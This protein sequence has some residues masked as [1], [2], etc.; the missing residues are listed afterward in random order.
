M[1]TG[2]MADKSNQEI[3][4]QLADLERREQEAA[5]LP[6]HIQ[7]IYSPEVLKKLFAHSLLIDMDDNNAK[8]DVI[9]ELVGDEDFMELGPGTN[10]VGLLGPDGCCHKIAMDRRGIVD[11]MTEFRRSP[12]LE[13][14]A[15]RAYETNGV[16]L[17]A[18]NVELMT[19][20]DY[21]NNRIHNLEICEALAQNYIFT[22]IGFA[23]K[24]FC[25][26]GIRQDGTLV[27]LDTGYL[28]PII[29]NEQALECP[30]CGRRLRYRPNY[31]GFTCGHCG[32]NFGFIDIY[33]RINTKV[34]DELY[35]GLTGFELP[36]F[37]QFNGTLYN[38]GLMKGGHI[39]SD[40]GTQV[41]PKFVPGTTMRFEDLQ[42]ILQRGGAGSDT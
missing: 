5:S 7:K 14:V 28:I 11:N 27:I 40:I 19:K 10:R 36:D 2:G 20:E 9:K 42:D 41:E 35:E 16:V 22:D 17:V 8:V 31:T 15:P 4:E 34:E 18:E 23:M 37:S 30:I 13:W 32:T 38:N 33:R 24:N 25:N 6:S 29:G 26:W 39:R 1:I 12:E 21:R 3:Q